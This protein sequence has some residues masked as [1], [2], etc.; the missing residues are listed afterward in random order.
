MN[1]V[2]LYQQQRDFNSLGM[3]TCQEKGEG[4]HTL[5]HFPSESDGAILH[6]KR[7]SV[8]EGAQFN[9][10]KAVSA[11]RIPRKISVNNLAY[12]FHDLIGSDLAVR[13]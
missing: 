2:N 10:G 3:N 9:E 8:T 5:P 11:R 12:F 7:G 6:A 13:G 4:G 1:T